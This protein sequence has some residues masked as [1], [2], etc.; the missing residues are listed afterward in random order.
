MSTNGMILPFQGPGV[1][2]P[3]LVS[4]VWLMVFVECVPQHELASVR[5]H[6]RGGSLTLNY[7]ASEPKSS[8][9]VNKNS[10]SEG[11]PPGH[12]PLRLLIHS[13]VHIRQKP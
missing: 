12:G 10:D 4:R 6:T 5:D 1:Q 9:F 2:W 7:T 13:G 8:K 11:P 3:T